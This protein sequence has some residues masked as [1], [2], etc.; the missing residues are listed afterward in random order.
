[1]F[2]FKNNKGF[3][4]LELLIVLMSMIVLIIGAMIIA[5]KMHPQSPD[6]NDSVSTHLVR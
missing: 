2:K 3:S 4:L 5:N 6:S 1:M